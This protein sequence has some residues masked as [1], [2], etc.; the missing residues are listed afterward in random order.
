MGEMSAKVFVKDIVEVLEVQFDGWAAYLNLDTGD[1]ETVSTDLLSEAEESEDEPDL[2]DDDKDEWEVVK[3]IVSTDR[4]RRLP[5][6]YEVNEWAIME[7]FS[8]SVE[9]DRIREE[10]MR[11]IHGSGAFR[12][13]KDTV[14]RRGI[15]RDWFAFRDEALRQIAID[16]CEENQIDW[17]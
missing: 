3:Q 16:W 11:A 9:S 15:E 5:G 8:R 17:R 2:S 7:D 6:Q 4:F 14:R 13:F 1:V 10:L 12:Y